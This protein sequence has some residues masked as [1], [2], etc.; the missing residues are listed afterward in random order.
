MW[1][2]ERSALELLDNLGVGALLIVPQTST[3]KISPHPKNLE[4]AFAALSL[5]F[6]VQLSC[7]AHDKAVVL[8]PYLQH[9]RTFDLRTEYQRWQAHRIYRIF[10]SRALA[11]TKRSDQ[12]SEPSSSWV[13]PCSMQSRAKRM[14]PATAGYAASRNYTSNTGQSFGVQQP[15]SY[16]GSSPY[17]SG[18]GYANAYSN[19]SYI[20]CHRLKHR[21]IFIPGIRSE[22]R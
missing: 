1:E 14:R 13:G 16:N 21:R 17:T 15:S 5:G 2:G 19:A 11:R 7:E 8:P 10:T 4:F 6:H 3:P 22:I 20:S 18:A 12:G 9:S